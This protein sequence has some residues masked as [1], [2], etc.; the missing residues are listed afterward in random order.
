VN[1]I[2]RL[3]ENRNKLREINLTANIKIWNFILDNIEE[4]DINTSSMNLETLNFAI[5]SEKLINQI[6]NQNYN[7][8]DVEKVLT[9]IASQVFKMNSI[10]FSIDNIKK[11][12]LSIIKSKIK[13]I[14]NCPREIQS[15]FCKNPNKQNCDEAFQTSMLNEKIDYLG[16]KACKAKPNMYIYDGKFTDKKKGAK[17]IDVFISNKNTRSEDFFLNTEKY[18]ESLI[19][20]GYQKTIMVSGGHQDNQ[21]KDILLFIN[22]ADQYIKNKNNKILFFVQADGGYCVDKMSKIKDSVVDKNK[23]F[24]G[25]TVDIIE[26]IINVS[27]KI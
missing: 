1:P 27:K 22:K 25:T 12:N 2:N 5:T 16:L 19:M 26:W 13:A 9:S 14:L 20:L 7:H 15:H 10:Q 11:I 3:Y 24:V 18:K 17:S 6:N 8:N 21:L 4:K 23:I